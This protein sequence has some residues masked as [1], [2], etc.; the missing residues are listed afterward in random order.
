MVDLSESIVR[1]APEI[2]AYKLGLLQSG[3]TLADTPLKL[4]EQQIAG[5]SGAEQEAFGRAGE[6]G[7]I[8]GYQALA[9]LGR[10]TLGS[11]VGT[12]D[13][14]RGAIGTAQGYLGDSRGAIGQA[15]QT[16]QGSFG[17]YGGGPGYTAQQ[18]GPGPAYDAQRFGPGSAYDAQRFGPGSAPATTSA[19]FNPYED[20]AVQQ[21]LSDIRRQGDIASNQLSASAVQA[22]A[23]GGSR[24]GIQ[25]GELERNILEQQGRT[26]ADM[27]QAG[28]NEP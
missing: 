10:G 23:F 24:E 27:R 12:L 19:F 28:Y 21:A 5:F 2:E 20:V 22:G 8:G 17:A 11:G 1:E 25:R 7:G 16:L 26:A 9:G 18:F 15:G 3:K 14:A 4:P 13:Q 6:V